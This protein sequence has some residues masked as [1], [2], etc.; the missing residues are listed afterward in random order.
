MI[1]MMI[2]PVAYLPGTWSVNTEPQVVAVT[3][4]LA[5]QFIKYTYRK[6]MDHNNSGLDRPPWGL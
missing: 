3:H 4:P 1:I 2:D 5:R 6:L